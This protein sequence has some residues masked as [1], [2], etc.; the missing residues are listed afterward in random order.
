MKGDGESI[1]LSLRNTAS[2]APLIVPQCSLALGSLPRN[3]LPALRTEKNSLEIAGLNHK[4]LKS[5]LKS[6]H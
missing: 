2:P 5:V 4:V 3:T 1:V 6:S